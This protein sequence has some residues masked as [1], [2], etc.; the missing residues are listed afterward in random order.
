MTMDHITGLSCMRCGREFPSSYSD[1]TCSD[2]G[3]DGI[4]DVHYDYEKIGSRTNR[5]GL[6]GAGMWRYLPLLPL[7][8]SQAPPPL[9]VGGTPL[10]APERLRR[11]TGHPSV[12]IKDDGRNPTGSLKDRASVV[13]LAR[14]RQEGAEA[15]TA[16]ST[17]NAACSIA[18]LTA[19][20]GIPCNIFVP[21][22]APRA[23]VAQLLVY[24]ARV[25]QVQGTYEQCFDLS[26]EASRRWGWYNR[27]CGYNP[28][29]V[30]GKKTVA[31]E[32]AEELNWQ[33]PD[34]VYVSVGDGCIVSG[35]YK[36]FYDLMQLGWIDTMPHLVAVQAAGASP[37][38]TA[39]E[40]GSE[41]VP[42]EP[43]TLADS[44][45]CGT[46]RNG[47]KALRALRESKGAAVSVTDEEILNSMSRLAVG[48]G[49]FGEPAGVTA[50][51]GFLKQ[52]EAGQVDRDER[53]VVLITGNGLK[54]V[55]SA[56]K[57]VG[58]P[59]RVE[60]TIEAIAGLVR[61]G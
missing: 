43:H 42:V 46:P 4:L 40:T 9:T 50:Y 41:I 61:T 26:V 23:K 18:G 60:P 10:Y 14:A 17:G 55:D 49:V 5:D 44:I 19:P 39:F 52:W 32:I 27:N 7:D 37:V 34:R 11:E 53:V 15:I 28:C 6:Q 13:G 57:A 48:S 51:A 31:Y 33:A 36:G 45:A 47:L 30:E 59:N 20:A 1:Y 25:F 21:E 35:V 8:D 22:R 56:F 3:V 12:Y 38:V 2:C 29:L 58:E 24:G 16:A 54:D